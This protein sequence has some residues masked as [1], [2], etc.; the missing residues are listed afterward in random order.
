VL[1]S[2]RGLLMDLDATSETAHADRA[3]RHFLEVLQTQLAPPCSSGSDLW[4]GSHET[5]R[6][7][8]MVISFFTTIGNYDY[9]F[10]WY[11]YLDGTT[12]CEV[13]ATGVVFTSAHPGKGYPYASEL[14]PGLG[15]PYHQH[16]FSARLDVAVDGPHNLVEEVDVRRVPIGPDNPRGNAFTHG[17]TRLRTES[18]ARRLA[19][20]RVGRVWHITNPTSLN[21]LGDPVA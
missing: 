20:N 17:R 8:R 3:F 11:L 15:A 12:E 21:R 18:Q 9:G 1:I 13:K 2:I 16:L 19:D 14:A 5:R 4:A 7:R 10:Y 6:Q